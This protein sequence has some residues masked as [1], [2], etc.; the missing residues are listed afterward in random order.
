MISLETKINEIIKILDTKFSPVGVKIIQNND[1]HI[2]NS[3]QE[4]NE[5]KRFCYY[6]RQAALGKKFIIKNDNK[7]ECKTP[8]YCLGFKEPKYGNFDYRI[9]PA[10]T[11]TVLIAPLNKFKMNVDS[12]V[13]IIN[14]KQS[15]LL[16][17]A[18]RRIQKKKIQATFGV[19]M[20][21]CGEIVANSIVN[22]TPSL[23]LLCYGARIYSDYKNN[24]LALGIPFVLFDS[25]YENLKKIEKLQELEEE[26]KNLEV[27]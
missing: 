22:K 15:M 21:I 14:A 27:K 9:R 26:L 16:V 20:S 23:S 4:V 2:D 17:D 18:L 13:F 12:V 19:S 24:E 3:F 8:Y 11:K 5:N 10:I 1:Q 7:L 25:I 6:V